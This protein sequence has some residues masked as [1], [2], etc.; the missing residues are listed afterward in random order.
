MPATALRTSAVGS[1]RSGLTLVLV[2]FAVAL[3]ARLV[4]TLRGGGVFGLH[5]YDDGVHY[6]AAMGLVHGRMPYRDFLLLHPPGIVV[7]LAPFAAVGRLIGDA[8]GFALTRLA[9]MALGAVNAVL[10][11]RFLRPVGAFAAWLGGLT[12]ALFWPAVYSEHTVL[13]EGPGNTC[14]LIALI[15]LSPVV[16]GS[17][18][19]SGG[20]AAS[21]D[22]VSR[23]R[24]VVAGALLG[25]ALSIKIWG[26]VPIVLL[27]GWLVYRF[28]IRPAA[29]F[30]IASVAATTVVCLPF[31]VQAPATMWRMVVRDQVERNDTGFRLYERLNEITGLTLFNLDERMSTRLLVVLVGLVAAIVLAATIRH[32][33]PAVIQLL[34]LTT[35]LLLTPSWFVHYSAL[36]ASGV[37]IVVGAAGQRVLDLALVSRHRWLRVGLGAALVLG[38]AAGSLPIASA[39]IGSTFPG[40]TLHRAVADR[41]GCVTSDHP[42]ALI[43]MNVLSRNLD[44]GCPLVVDLGGAGYDLESPDRGVRSRRHNAVFQAYAL[45]YLRT[46]DASVLARFRKNY[47]LNT[48]SFRT[49]AGWPVLAK[50][51]KYR[52][53]HPAR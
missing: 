52:L 53:R 22:V 43:L 14:L 6:A 5:F 45:A 11:S 23:A 24:L 47:G 18:P 39:S 16:T 12:Y 20:D 4:P 41:P 38:L 44:R 49:V 32:T 36:T 40:R 46:G 7:L 3:L 1:R 17:A 25:F 30:L 27:L 15:L 19:E 13:L 10:V 51:G 28:G 50:A 35:L 8:N 31:F 48:K 37:A 21:R 42:S 26:V 2:V 33:Q 29:T 34:G 9:F